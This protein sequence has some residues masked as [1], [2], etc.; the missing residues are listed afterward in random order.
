MISV[1]SAVAEIEREI[2]AH[3]QWQDG[4]KRLV[5]ANG[6]AVSLHMDTNWKMETLSFAEDEVEV[7]RVI[8]TV[9]FTLMRVLQEL[10][11]I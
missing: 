5:K 6:T 2:S 4:S 3:R 9:T 1:L 11:N 7:I 8:M 10:Q